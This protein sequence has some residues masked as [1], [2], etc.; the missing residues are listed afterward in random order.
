MK[1][2][3]QIFFLNNKSD[4]TNWGLGFGPSQTLESKL[5]QT[6][7]T[8]VNCFTSKSFPFCKTGL[9]PDICGLWEFNAIMYINTQHNMWLCSSSQF[10]F[11]LPSG[12]LLIWLWKE[13]NT[14]QLAPTQKHGIF[15]Y[16]KGC[17]GHWVQ[18]PHFT[19]EKSKVP[20]WGPR[21]QS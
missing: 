19:D 12:A 8:W 15:L 1:L 20:K 18:N 4:S 10:F 16:C 3:C 9:T 2:F 17:K 13:E 21:S 6:S 5:D 11:F 14:L 7:P